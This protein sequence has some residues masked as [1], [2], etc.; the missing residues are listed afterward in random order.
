ANAPA[1][2]SGSRASSERCDAVVLVAEHHGSARAAADSGRVRVELGADQAASSDLEEPGV[3]EHHRLA[4]RLEDGPVGELCDNVVIG[5][6]DLID[7]DVEG[8]PHLCAAGGSSEE[9]S[10]SLG[11]GELPA[12]RKRGRDGPG[13][14]PPNFGRGD[15]AVARAWWTRR[16]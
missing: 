8:L 10:E 16:E 6:D 15:A 3:L 1:R 5:L 9:L 4:G 7:V 2:S 13:W 11:A 12:V 14:A